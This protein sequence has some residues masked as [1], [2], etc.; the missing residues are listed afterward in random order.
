MK[1]STPPPA[2]G[3]AVVRVSHPYPILLADPGKRFTL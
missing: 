2:N 1:P 3:L